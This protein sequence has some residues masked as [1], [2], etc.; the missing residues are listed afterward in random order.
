MLRTRLRTTSKA[1]RGLAEPKNVRFASA[2]TAPA[3]ESSILESLFGKSSSPRVPMDHPY[4]NLPKLQPQTLVKH[5]P[6]IS[7]LDN[8]VRVVSVDS[9]QPLASVGVLVNAGSRYENPTIS[10]VSD[11]LAS[12]LFKATKNRSSFL[13][14]REMGKAGS[15]F[16]AASSRE[17]VY[18]IGDG[19]REST[20]AMVNT[21][22]DVIQNPIF[23]PQELTEAYEAYGESLK[24]QDSLLRLKEAI[25]AAAYH[26][27]T[28]G[29]PTYAT[30]PKIFS[31]EVLSDYVANLFTADRLVLSG[32]GVEHD[33]FVELAA[34]EFGELPKT[35]AVPTE[36]AKYTGGDVRLA[37]DDPMAHVAIG[38][39]TASWLDKDLVPL[40][41]LSMMMGGGGSF[42]A[43][44]PGKG[45]YSRLYQ[46]VLMQH[47]WVVS[48]QSFN[49]I[50]S[51]SG[52]FGFEGTC[53]AEQAGSLVDV[54]CNEIQ[55]ASKV[56]EASLERAKAQLASSMLMQLESRPCVMED[57]GRQLLTFGKLL[58]TEE[59]LGQI[60]AVTAADIQ[61]VASS[62]LKTPS[63]FAAV[64]NLSY[65]PHSD[66]IS[67]RFG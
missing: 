28:L 7:T 45:M 27:N 33:K 59:T 25:Q 23:D 63:S 11:F 14:S 47:Q 38:F 41:V 10:G 34:S 5:Q 52:L 19:L 2:L 55:A 3:P 39:E 32:V 44:G 60:K 29:L 17:A 21:L 46:N 37:T 9:D 13:L 53:E 48:A 15:T 66:V 42:S 57:Q 26:N 35:S 64:G 31:Q 61:R 36:K 24:N 54:L 51:D 6:T 4:P 30:D 18:A 40:C 50:S 22:A 12:F 62:M 49:C 43:G 20:P 16:A 1:F 58:T 67:K 65:L 56:D 8:G